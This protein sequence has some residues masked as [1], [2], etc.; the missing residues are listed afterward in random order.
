MAESKMTGLIDEIEKEIGICTAE[1][2]KS[3]EIIIKETERKTCYDDRK[4]MLQ[5]LLKLAKECEEIGRH[6][7]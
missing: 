5:G 2:R 4:V 1:I 3:N 7:F 6:T